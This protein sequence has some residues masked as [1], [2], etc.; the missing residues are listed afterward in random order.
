ME[1]EQRVRKRKKQISSEVEEMGAKRERGE[2]DKDG[3]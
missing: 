2:V 1:W 3:K